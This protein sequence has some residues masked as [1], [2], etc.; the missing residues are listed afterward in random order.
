M[1]KNKISRRLHRIV[2]ARRGRRCDSNGLARWMEEAEN[3][4][5]NGGRSGG[6]MDHPF[7]QAHLASSD[8]GDKERGRGKLQDWFASERQLDE[9]RLTVLL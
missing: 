4:G 5:F 3:A 9:N 7:L 1:S 2:L 8:D 6:R